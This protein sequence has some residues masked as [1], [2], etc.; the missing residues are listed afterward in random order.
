MQTTSIKHVIVGWQFNCTDC[1]KNLKTNLGRLSKIEILFQFQ[2]TNFR[3]RL[4]S[5]N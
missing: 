2:D 3:F 5:E 1:I 4:I